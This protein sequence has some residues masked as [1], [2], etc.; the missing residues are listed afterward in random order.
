MRDYDPAE[1]ERIIEFGDRR[2]AAKQ[3]LWLQ[4]AITTALAVILL[5]ALIVGWIHG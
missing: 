2:R 1:L 5:G 3:R 4:T